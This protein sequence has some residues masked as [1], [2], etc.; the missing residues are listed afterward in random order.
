MSK[1]FEPIPNFTSEEAGKRFREAINIEL[2]ALF[3]RVQKL[4]EEIAT[5]HKSKQEQQ[6]NRPKFADGVN[7]NPLDPDEVR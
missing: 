2:G 1:S 3:D 7:R 5:L 6:Q 4:E